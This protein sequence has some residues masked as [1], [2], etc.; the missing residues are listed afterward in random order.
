MRSDTLKDCRVVYREKIVRS[1]KKKKN[2]ATVRARLNW[3]GEA[4]RTSAA[5]KMQSALQ[6]KKKTSAVRPVKDPEEMRSKKRT[7][8]Y[9]RGKVGG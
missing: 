6:K 9:A 1:D 4:D 3:S 7:R 8:R 2:A 5:G